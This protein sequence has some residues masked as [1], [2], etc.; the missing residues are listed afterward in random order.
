[1]ANNFD[2]EL[3]IAGSGIAGTAGAIFAREQGF[4]VVQAGSTAEIV[5]ASGLLDVYGSEKPFMA[6]ETLKTTSPLHPYSKIGAHNTRLAMNTVIKWLSK[7]GMPF[8]HKNDL[9]SK[10]F[11]PMG[12]S[13]ITWAVPESFYFGVEALEKKLPTLLIDFHGLREYSA[14]QIAEVG[15]K[16]NHDLTAVKL[17]FPCDIEQP[18][19]TG[20]MAQ[21]L[22]LPENLEALAALIKP[23]LRQMPHIACVGLPAILGVHNSHVITKR[24][25]KLIGVPAFEIPTLP[26]SVPGFRLKNIFDEYLEKDKV[27]TRRLMRAFS[28][29]KHE[30][31][32][33]VS[34]NQI[35]QSEIVE[36]VYTKHIL[37]ATGRFIGNGLYADPVNGVVESVMNLPVHQPLERELW[38][39]EDLFHKRGHPINYA[40]VMVNDEFMP[41]DFKGQVLHKNVYA[42]GTLL[43]HHDWMREKCGT[44]I[45]VASAYMAVKN[46]VKKNK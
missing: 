20:S 1:M 13:K 7:H 35:G 23:Y 32:Y 41:V 10:V 30:E 12:G 9:S 43:A 14:K 38:H 39:N 17:V 25:S 42:A 8:K 36:E 40:G 33:L 6:I 19:M 26:A 4:S 34:L 16:K 21:A 28:V 45:A 18:L 31:G 37:L 22:E 24:L 27:E 3:F 29:K 44:G 11:T 15:K 2:C 46:M 5:F